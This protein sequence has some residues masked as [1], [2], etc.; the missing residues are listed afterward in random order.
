MILNELGKLYS[1]EEVAKQLNV[2]RQTSL[3]MDEKERLTALKLGGT[4]YRVPKKELEYFIFKA[5]YSNSKEVK[6][7]NKR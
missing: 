4:V 1:I 6:I 3:R 5:M 7:C 2:S